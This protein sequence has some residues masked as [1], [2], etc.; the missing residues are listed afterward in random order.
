MKQRLL[1]P[2]KSV[3]FEFLRARWAITR[4]GTAI[5]LT[6]KVP[7][8]RTVQSCSAK[9]SRF[10]AALLDEVLIAIIKMETA[11]E[12]S[13]RGLCRIAAIP[14]LLC[15]AQKSH[16]CLPYTLSQLVLDR[17]E[18]LGKTA[19]ITPESSLLLIPFVHLVSCLTSNESTRASGFQPPATREITFV[20]C[21]LA[22]LLSPKQVQA[23]CSTFFN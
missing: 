19:F 15:L 10:T 22:V 5:G 6:K 4:V 21:L 17:V 23:L 12:L 3:R 2:A 20:I 14:L 9:P 7:R 8:K 13:R 11:R 18:D 16:F 1:F